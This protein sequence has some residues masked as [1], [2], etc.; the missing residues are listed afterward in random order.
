[1]KLRELNI[2]DRFYYKGKK[3]SR[4]IVESKPQF[5][6]CGTATMKCYNE[7]L[8]CS[9]DKICNKEVVLLPP[10]NLVTSHSIQ[11]WRNRNK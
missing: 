2:G 5:N 7:L 8:K 4:W 11:E 1:M 3:N 6:K 9:F 10:K